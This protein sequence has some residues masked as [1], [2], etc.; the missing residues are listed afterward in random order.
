LA[1]IAVLGQVALARNGEPSA[2]SAEAAQRER[3]LWATIEGCVFCSEPPFAMG[4]LYIRI[5][6]RAVVWRSYM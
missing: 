2:R 1:V 5:R 4:G 3:E 6:G